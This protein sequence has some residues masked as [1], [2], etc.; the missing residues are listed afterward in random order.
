MTTSARQDGSDDAASA[1]G[2]RLTRD[3]VVR[4]AL[5]LIDRQGLRDL[6]MRRL[7]A[8]LGVEAMSLYRY[9]AGR[10]D[11][12]DAVIEAV[13]AELEAEPDDGEA[14]GDR[15]QGFLQQLAHSVRRVALAHPQLF[16]LLATRHPAAPWIRPPLRSLEWIET[17][18]RGLTTRGF[19][20]ASAVAAY[21]A[22]TS[23]LLGHLLLEVSSRTEAPVPVDGEVHEVA[24]S[25]DDV[26]LADY[27][28]IGQL[29]H[30][31]RQDHSRS[32]FEESLENLLDRIERM[33]SA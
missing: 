29:E 6:S 8:T 13:V 31:L 18:L 25:A 10:E 27:P 2:D 19:S 15:W 20:D 7:G 17:F 24:S 1:P 4:A 11:L 28:C 33:S 16:P 14:P 21:R 32:E 3:V 22:F 9:V 12:L 30:L 23:F 26:D 5:D